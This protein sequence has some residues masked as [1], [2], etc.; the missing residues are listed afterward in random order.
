MEVVRFEDQSG[1][2]MWNSHT[3]GRLRLQVSAMEAVGLEEEF[4]VTAAL[5]YVQFLEE[6][7]A[8]AAARDA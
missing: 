5:A 4:W 7:D 8:Y 2:W 6:K 1:R 3:K